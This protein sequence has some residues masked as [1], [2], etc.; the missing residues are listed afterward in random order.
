MD[1]NVISEAPDALS[2]LDRALADTW[3]P[4]STFVPAAPDQSNVFVFFKSLGDLLSATSVA[5]LSEDV[6]PHVLYL[7]IHADSHAAHLLQG[8]AFYADPQVVLEAVMN[9]GSVLRAVVDLPEPLVSADLSALAEPLED[10]PEAKSPASIPDDV[11]AHGDH[12]ASHAD[13]HVIDPIQDETFCAEL[14]AELEGMENV[15]DEVDQPTPEIATDS[16]TPILDVVLHGGSFSAEQQTV[17]DGLGSIGTALRAALENRPESVPT[18][19][20]A[21]VFS[22]IVQAETKLAGWCTREKALCLVRT[23]L[24]ERPQVCVEI[25]I[26]G[27]RSLIPCAAALQ[28]IGS[29]VIY[30]VEAWSPQVAVAHATNQVNDDW[31]S[32]IDFTRIKHDFLQFVV[33][34]SLAAQVRIIEVASER[35]ATLFDQI[36]FLHI[37]GSHSIVNAADDVIRYATKV[38]RGGIVVFDDINWQSTAPARELL[39]A[40][41]ETITILKDPESGQ[42]MCAVFRRR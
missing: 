2:L 21:E 33:D 20:P 17:L 25:G 34:T 36:D 15:E 31:W 27:G 16:F 4:L 18:G 24:Q 28:H 19:I 39:G 40:L 38:R 32:K 1:V 12:L 41:C 6:M 10:M 9:I 7:A 22:I 5:G 37:D 23:I 29:G 11:V 14:H 42:D 26:F 35:A 8:G 13:P 3:Q 30:G